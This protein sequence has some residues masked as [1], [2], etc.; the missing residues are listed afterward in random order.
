MHFVSAVQLTKH[1]E[2][3]NLSPAIGRMEKIRLDPEDFHALRPAIPRSKAGSTDWPRRKTLPQTWRLYRFQMRSVASSSP[4]RCRDRRPDTA[5]LSRYS[6]M[7][8][9]GASIAS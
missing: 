1:L 2:R 7:R 3:T 4:L 8:V 6:E 9:P 5:L